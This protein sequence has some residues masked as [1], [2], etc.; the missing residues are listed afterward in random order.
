[1]KINHT[2][3]VRRGFTLIELLVVIAIIAVLAA[4][5]FAG[6]TAAKEA[7]NKTSAKNHIV[8]LIQAVDTYYDD[9]SQL[10]VPDGG[11]VEFRTD[12]AFMGIL[13]GL[14]SEPYKTKNP[15]KTSFFSA[16]KAKGAAPTFKNGL[17]RTSD[18]AELYDPWGKMYYVV[19]DTDYN[20]EIGPPV[21][22]VASNNETIFGNRALVWSRGRDKTPL[23]NDDVKSWE[24]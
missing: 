22:D 11:S 19:L 18:V 1:M 6:F 12:T 9:Y 7:A 2:H 15:K 23:G 3:N 20:N 8:G 13:V 10:P 17:N 4:L 24:Q 14:D 5:G 21:P 16:G